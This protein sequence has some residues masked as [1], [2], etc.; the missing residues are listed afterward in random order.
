ME[1]MFVERL[2]QK[3]GQ[4]VWEPQEEKFDLQSDFDIDEASLNAEICRMGQLLTRYGTLDAEQSANLKRMEEYAKLVKA[5]V[6]GAQRSQ[7]EATHTKMTENKLEELVITSP[8]YQDALNKLHILRADAIKADHWWRAILKKAE[9]LN[10][11]A[12]RQNAEL[13]RMPG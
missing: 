3:D 6:A 4:W 1:T 8:H 12:F 7:A 13:K 5:Q 10:A 11:M 9:L 2:V